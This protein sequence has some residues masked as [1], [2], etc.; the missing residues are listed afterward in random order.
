[1]ST[2]AEAQTPTNPPVPTARSGL[3]SAYA[4][5]RLVRL[6]LASRRIPGA[7]AALLVCT[8]LM[9]WALRATLSQSNHISGAVT[10]ARQLT[11]LLESLAAAVVSAAMHGPFGEPERA[12]GRRL[13][14][15]RLACAL[16]LIAAAF[17]ALSLGMVGTRLPG[18]EL[19]LIRDTAG[20]IGIGLICTVLIGGHF[21]WVGPAGYFV[22]AAYGVSEAWNTPWTWPSRPPHDTGA[23]LCAY[24]LLA[25]ATLAVTVFGARENP[26]E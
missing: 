1:V 20:L 21:A 13:P 17:T 15:L 22:V 9:Q 16:V 2:L 18:G 10:S 12:A 24:L 3:G 11:L 4:L 25:G 5:A 8:V 19:A 23:A 14:L 6:H 7:L 26:R